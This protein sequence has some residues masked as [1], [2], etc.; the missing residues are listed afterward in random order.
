ML[1][2]TS[3]TE[4]ARV[5]VTIINLKGEVDSSNH[6]VFQTEGEAL[7]NQGARY[8]LI[9]LKEVS[10]MSSAGLRVIHTLFNKL[11]EVH[12]D[13][14]D[15]ELRKKMRAGAYKSSYIKVVDL[16]SALRELFVLSGFD[17]YIEPFDDISSAIKSF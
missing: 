9:N 17:T 13:V 10:Y 11:R 1:E 7:I 16:S 15:D 3:T 8:L 5:P 14:N 2:I 4:N 12:K 6:Q